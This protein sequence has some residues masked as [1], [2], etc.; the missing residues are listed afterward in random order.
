MASD[1]PVP[2]FLIELDTMSCVQLLV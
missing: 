2:V 1:W